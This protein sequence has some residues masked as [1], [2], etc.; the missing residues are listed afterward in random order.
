MMMDR[1]RSERRRSGEAVS[2]GDERRQ[3]ERRVFTRRKSPRIPTVLWAEEQSGASFYFRR[4]ANLSEGGLFFDVALPISSGTRVN[5]R[6]K[7]PGDSGV[8]VAKGRVVRAGASAGEGLGIGIEF[9][10]LEG[11]GQERVGALIRAALAEA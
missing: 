5:L 10:S 11:D 3:G 1:R 7:L 2:G 6:L 4:V 9:T 8:V